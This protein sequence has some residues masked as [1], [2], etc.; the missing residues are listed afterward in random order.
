MKNTRAQFQAIR[1][2]YRLARKVSPLAHENAVTVYM[3][4]V[5]AL[6]SF[7]GKWDCCEPINLASTYEQGKKRGNHWIRPIHVSAACTRFFKGLSHV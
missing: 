2:A 3:S 6:R 1:R 5:S 7:T 4:T